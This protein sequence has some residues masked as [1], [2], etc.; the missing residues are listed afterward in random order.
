MYLNKDTLFEN[1][2][3]G[4]HIL[5]SQRAWE[6]G[7]GSPSFENLEDACKEY[8]ID[9]EKIIHL[10]GIENYAI[11]LTQDTVII[12]DE[13]CEIVGYEFSFNGRYSIRGAPSIL[14]PHSDEYGREATLRQDLQRFLG[15]SP[16]LSFLNLADLYGALPAWG[17]ADGDWIREVKVDGQA[18]DEFIPIEYNGKEYLIWIFHNL[19]TRDSAADVAITGIDR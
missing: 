14:L 16:Y 3:D 10:F 19:E 7:V 18:P 11:V 6:R 2:I 4:D 13:V 15:K 8:G 12:V 17:I 9:E 1:P 5:S